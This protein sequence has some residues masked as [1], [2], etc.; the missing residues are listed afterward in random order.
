[1]V[2]GNITIGNLFISDLNLIDENRGLIWPIYKNFNHPPEKI[3][4][5]TKLKNLPKSSKHWGVSSS[6]TE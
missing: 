5:I 1:M 4:S 3:G 2:F 6:L